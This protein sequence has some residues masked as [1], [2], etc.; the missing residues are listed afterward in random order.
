MRLNMWMIKNKLEGL[1]LECDIH[2]V[3]NQNLRSAR[4]VYAPNCIC[5][6]QSG[7]DTLCSAG[8]ERILIKDISYQYAFELLQGIF[9]YYNDWYV[10]TVMAAKQSNWQEIITRLSQVIKQPVV[11]FDTNNQ[12]VAMAAPEEND[13]AIDKEWEYLKANGVSSIQMMQIGIRNVENGENWKILY[14]KPPKGV[15]V[16]APTLNIRISENGKTYGFI[17]VLEMNHTFNDGDKK[18]LFALA[19]IVSPAFALFCNSCQSHISS[20]CFT[21]LLLNR[22]INMDIMRMEELCY[23]F[24]PTSLFRLYA[25]RGDNTSSKSPL[26]VLYLIKR[27]ILMS[28]WLIPMAEVDDLLVV[29]VNTELDQEQVLENVLR[30]LQEYERFHVARSQICNDLSKSWAYYDQC[31]YVLQFPPDR[32]KVWHDFSC[33]A[34]EYMLEKS[35]PEKLLC[36]RHDLFK[37]LATEKKQLDWDF[38]RSFIVYLQH[39]RSL[40]KAAQSLYVHKN[41]LIYRLRKVE[42]L[43]IANL[44]S[45]YEREHILLSYR[46]TARLGREPEE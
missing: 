5:V 10:Q 36:A 24:K 41:T 1:E 13:N 4:L 20:N 2:P 11:F 21:E 33:H 38:L 14:H 35:N 23:N 37:Q 6:C 29:F 40:T 7:E 42:S 32:E 34:I 18:L 16:A 43:Q 3:S 15:D 46:V 28:T 44:D 31:K 19:D 39:E 22:N 45:P 25:I 9:D 26:D 30:Q 12:V 8:D 17:C 27:A